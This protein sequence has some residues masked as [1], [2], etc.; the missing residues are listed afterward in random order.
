MRNYK[1]INEWL[2]Q[3]DVRLA[4]GFAETLRHYAKEYKNINNITLNEVYSRLGCSKQNVSY[5]ETHC[6]STQSG[7]TIL[8]VVRVAKELFI[9]TDDEAE[10]LANSAGLSLNYEGGN[11]IEI[12]NYSG[13][14]CDLSSNALISERMLRYYKKKSHKAGADGNHAL[15]KSSAQQAAGN[16]QE[17]W[18]LFVGKR[19]RRYGSEMV[20]YISKRRGQENIV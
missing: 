14:V 13:K 7:R 18:V 19:C 5:W 12:L 8:R 9:L 10:K 2:G 20:H 1:L 11:L 16:S 3:R 15:I 6:D 17:I 4:A